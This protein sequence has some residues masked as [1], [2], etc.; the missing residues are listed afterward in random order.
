[1]SGTLQKHWHKNKQSYFTA[2]SSISAF[3]SIMSGI[4]YRHTNEEPTHHVYPSQHHYQLHYPSLKAIT[5]IIIIFIQDHHQ[6]H[7]DDGKWILLAETI[8]ECHGRPRPQQHLLVVICQH[9]WRPWPCLHPHHWPTVSLHHH[10]C[11]VLCV[12]VGVVGRRERG[13]I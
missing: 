9:H 3:S 13:N 5:T 7:P 1:M 8:G 2:P 12:V 11:A 10:H 4:L 6:P